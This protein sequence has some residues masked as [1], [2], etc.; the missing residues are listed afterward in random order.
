MLKNY[1]ELDKNEKNTTHQANLIEIGMN[2]KLPSK[3]IYFIV[4]E[5]NL[6]VKQ[7][8]KKRLKDESEQQNM[9]NQIIRNLIYTKI[10]IPKENYYKSRITRFFYVL[11]QMPVFGTV[12]LF[13]ILLNTIFLSLERYPMPESEKNAYENVNYFFSSIFAVEVVLKIIGLS[14]RKFIM[15][16]FN[17]FDSIIVLVSL[18]EL[19][20]SS[21]SGGVSALRAFRLFRIFKLFRTGNLRVLLDSIAYTMGTIGN[22]AILLGLFIY[23]YSL[24]GMQF[25]AGKL[26]FDSEGFY[27]ANGEVSRANFDTIYWAAITVFEVLIGDNWNDVMFDCIKS[28]GLL[29]TIYF[30]SLILF[31]SIIMLNLFLAI[32]LGNFDKARTF[33]LKKTI[34]EMFETAITK[35]YS[36]NKAIFI[37]LGD[38]D[39]SVKKELLIHEPKDILRI[40]GRLMIIN[41]KILEN[42]PEAQDKLNYYDKIAMYETDYKPIVEDEEYS[43]GDEDEDQEFEY[44][45]SKLKTKKSKPQNILQKIIEEHDEFKSENENFSNG[46]D[47][48]ESKDGLVGKNKRSTTLK[49]VLL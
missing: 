20:L 42:D 29:S 27:D 34:F 18:L 16:K 45:S 38:M 49:Y 2:T 48:N 43:F 30:I 14:P 31:G 12:I 28:V 35:N 39:K 7:K 32:L 1:D 24:L 21:G 11:V 46:K 41:R 40:N 36:L 23:V 26:T 13:C 15:D 47:L 8:A 17:I 33:W 6:I 22:Y 9:K 3:L 5:E 4:G 19:F 10:E 25:F 37:I 44:A